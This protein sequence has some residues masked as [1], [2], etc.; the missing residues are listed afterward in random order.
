MPPEFFLDRSLGRHVAEGLAELDWTVHRIVDHFPN[1]AQDIADEFGWRTASTVV[2]RPYARTVA[3]R[4][5]T[6]SGHREATRWGS[7]ESGLPGSRDVERARRRGIG[8]FC[9][10]RACLMSHR[11]QSRIIEPQLPGSTAS[12]PP[13]GQPTPPCGRL[14]ERGT[15]PLLRLAVDRDVDALVVEAGQTSDLLALRHR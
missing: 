10:R 7:T 8:G 2:G 13:I 9:H 4:A 3:S 15:R 12:T 1:D 6:R 5:A 14:A 11:G